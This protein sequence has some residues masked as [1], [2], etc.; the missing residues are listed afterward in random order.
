MTQHSNTLLLGQITLTEPAGVFEVIVLLKYKCWSTKSRPEERPVAAD[1]T[2]P[3]SP[4]RQISTGS[5]SLL[6]VVT[7]ELLSS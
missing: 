2:P 6:W 1:L 7:D 3:P 4:P 5:T